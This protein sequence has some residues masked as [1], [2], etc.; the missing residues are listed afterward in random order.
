MTFSDNY[1]KHL[2]VLENVGMTKIDPVLY[3]GVEIVPLKFL[4]A[5]LAISWRRSC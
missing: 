3:D 2:E 4:K 5:V 1:L